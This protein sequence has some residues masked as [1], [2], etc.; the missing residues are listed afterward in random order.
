[1]LA[2]RG[3]RTADRGRDDDRILRWVLKKAYGLRNPSADQLRNYQHWHAVSRRDGFVGLEPPDW[4]S[5]PW[6][7]IPAGVTPLVITHPE[8]APPPPTVPCRAVETTVDAV[9]D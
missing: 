6:K 9:E 4:R 1:V 2:G 3:A 7:P 5:W 8:P